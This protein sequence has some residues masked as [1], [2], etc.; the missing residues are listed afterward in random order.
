MADYPTRHSSKIKGRRIFPGRSPKYSAFIELVAQS[1]PNQVNSRV[2]RLMTVCRG[3]VH[4]GGLQEVVWV[5]ES[6]HS[7]VGLAYHL[8][9]TVAVERWSKDIKEA[10]IMQTF[11]LQ[12]CMSVY[13]NDDGGRAIWSVDTEELVYNPVVVPTFFPRVGTRPPV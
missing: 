1:F 12:I 2:K 13:R 10:D 8:V 3:Y 6:P 4:R 7:L 11:S 5:L 9:R